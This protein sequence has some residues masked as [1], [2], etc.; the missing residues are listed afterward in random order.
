[1]GY[2]REWHKGRDVKWVWRE[3]GRFK[4]VKPGR[5]EKGRFT[6]NPGTKFIEYVRTFVWRTEEEGVYWGVDVVEIQEVPSDFSEDQANAYLVDPARM[7]RLKN[8]LHGDPVMVEGG[9]K[10]RLPPDVVYMEPM[11]T[12]TGGWR[13]VDVARV[14]EVLGG[15]VGLSWADLREVRR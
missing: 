6:K 1:M 14:R 10:L 5:D 7:V 15:V 9:K 4:S 11:E 13:G 12:K 8:Y 2:E 3:N